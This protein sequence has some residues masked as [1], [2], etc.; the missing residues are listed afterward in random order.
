MSSLNVDRGGRSQRSK[1]SASAALQALAA[2]ASHADYARRGVPIADRNIR[3]VMVD[4][5]AILRG[6]LRALLHAA[7]DVQVVGEATNGKDAVEVVQR[8]APDVVVLDLDMPDGDGGTATRE[9]SRLE[10]AP[11]I[12]I[13]TMHSEEERLVPLL[14]DGALGILSKDCSERDHIDAIRV[15]ANGDFFVRPTV[16]RI[17]AANAMPRPRR[18]EI[19]EAQAK[20]DS[21]SA[22][23]R[24]VLRRVAEGYS[25]VEIARALGITAKTIDTYKNRIAEKLGFT[26][27]TEY[28]R[29]ALG[30]GLL[31]DG[32]R[33]NADEIPHLHRQPG[34]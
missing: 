13:L 5:H 7:P 15:V 23:E 2:R 19:D 8:L 31:G 27:R 16:A 29:F 20:L 6:A 9:L 28:V 10:P 33:R 4:D 22:R 32:S 26:H 21:L 12:L 17:L 34:L 30:L 1:E 3:V 24:V 18:P 14:T 25:G 11:K